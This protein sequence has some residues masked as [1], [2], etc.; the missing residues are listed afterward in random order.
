MVSSLSSR[1]GGPDA[2][3]TVPHDFSTNV[4]AAGPCLQVLSY[5]QRLVPDAYPDPSHAALCRQLGR[6]HG[7]DPRRILIGAS[8]SELI[9]RLTAAVVAIAAENVGGASCTHTDAETGPETLI[10]TES[11]TD[12]DR[13]AETGAPVSVHLPAHAYGDYRRA[14]EAW[15]LPVHCL[16]GTEVDRSL[17]GMSRSRDVEVI[18]GSG[19]VSGLER[20]SDGRPEA[21][22]APVVSAGV[23]G[24]EDVPRRTRPAPGRLGKETASV[25]GAGDDSRDRQRS[26]RR[27]IRLIWACE[28]SSPLGVNQPGLPVW[29]Q[30]LQAPDVLVLDRAYAPMRLEG[31][32]SLDACAL[33]RVWQLITPNKALGLTGI[34]A[35]YLIAPAV[36]PSAS[37]RDGLQLRL[38]AKMRQ[39]A[40]SWEIGSHGVALLQQWMEPGPQA[41]LR[42][43]LALLR[44]WKARQ[45][46][47]LRARGWVILDSDS[48]FFCARS[49][50]DPNGER[51]SADLPAPSLSPERA[52]AGRTGDDEVWEGLLA[53][54]RQAGIKLRDARSFGLPGWARM[55]VRPPADQQALWR[56][57]DAWSAAGA[58]VKPWLADAA[59]LAAWS[60]T[61][62]ER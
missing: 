12:T 50:V 17:P 55:S 19:V 7:I 49:P 15:G 14:A 48:H 25:G 58:V 61:Q 21:K 9:F 5:L 54:L 26:R 4:N 43:S 34:R 1:H 29:V 57:L 8:G 46:A 56:A 3:G 44:N 23:A 38:L 53:H 2:Q 10:D 47:G 32:G 51:T 11:E 59:R 42:D 22:V 31:Q 40:P 33:G 24:H 30:Q 35:A 37:V 36:S 39:L 60:S 27:G 13:A 18:D 62:G 41:W 45:V 16:P 28:P 6:W 52:P 20:C